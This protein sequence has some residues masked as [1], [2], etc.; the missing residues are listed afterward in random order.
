MSLL[1][2]L[3]N[4]LTV[5]LIPHE[6]PFGALVLGY[7]VGAAHEEEATEGVAHLLEHLL[8]E[9]DRIAYDARLQAVGGST[10]AYTGQDYTVYYA[11]FPSEALPL[12]LEL[13]AERLFRLQ[14]DPQK[15]EIQKQ[16]VAEEF[17][18]RYLNP[19]YADR[20]F[21]LARA[22][23]GSHPYGTM[24][25]GRSPEQVL[26]LSLADLAY[27]YSAYY[28]PAHAVLCVAGPRL[29]AEVE[30]LI[31]AYFGHVRPAAAL[32]EVP[33]AETLPPPTPYI[34]LE[35]HVPQTAVIW[36]YRLPP[37]E[38]PDLPAI[39]LLD[40]YLGEARAG[41]LVKRLVEEAGLASRIVTY[42]WSL[43][44]GGLWVIEGYLNAGVAPA[45]YEA[46]LEAALEALKEADLEEVLALYRPKRYLQVHRQREKVLDKALA[47]VHAVLAGHP[48]WYEDPLRPYQTLTAA[49][50]ARAVRTY[51]TPARRVCLH[52]LARK[53]G[54]TA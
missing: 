41:F 18:Q 40:D 52:Y 32:P 38:H 46:A 8:F 22:A 15:V 36:A 13:E 54:A 49:D 25:I 37:L 45:A 39:D 48:E 42:V 29:D 7:K 33:S 44:Q 35:A 19:P 20:F 28:A 31:Q 24:V 3:A 11:R 2:T 5:A 30:G 9:D 47:L 14:L 23:F 6:G 1:Y 27:F 21:H 53:N 12:A 17:R 34:A 50:L 16:V 51:L 26:T 43:H 4:D 10:N